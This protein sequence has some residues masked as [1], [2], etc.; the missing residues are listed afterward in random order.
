MI[1]QETVYTQHTHTHTHFQNCRQRRVCYC[2]VNE[3][4][5]PTRMWTCR[6][7]I[8]GWHTFSPLVKWRAWLKFCTFCWHSAFIPSFITECIK[9]ICQLNLIWLWCVGLIQEFLILSTVYVCVCV[10]VCMCVCVVCARVCVLCVHVC[11]CIRVHVCLCAYVCMCVCACVCMLCT[12]CLY[13]VH[14]LQ[15]LVFSSCKIWLLEAVSFLLLCSVHWT[16]TNQNYEICC[17]SNLNTMLMK[18]TTPW[19]VAGW[20][21]TWRFVKEQSTPI[22]N[23][24]AWF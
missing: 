3:R 4:L 2:G 15:V 19:L 12:E 5:P 24:H 22:G 18:T 8:W 1:A 6:T 14:V 16:F 11:V 10:C 17:Q 13:N 21:Q 23:R 9:K 20:K 7:S